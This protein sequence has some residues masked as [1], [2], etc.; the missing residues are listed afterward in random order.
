MEF[1]PKININ[2]RIE[3]TET[4]EQKITRLEAEI[5]NLKD[6]IRRNDEGIELLKLSVGALE[7]RKGKGYPNPEADSLDI[8]NHNTA[9]SN[10]IQSRRQNEDS[11]TKKELELAEAKQ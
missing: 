10:L 5:G 2:T 3:G 6:F 7:D 1:G 9:I 11:L 4:K 8:L